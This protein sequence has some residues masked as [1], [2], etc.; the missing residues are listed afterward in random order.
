MNA[1]GIYVIWAV[2]V[3]LFT[4]SWW[5]GRIRAKEIHSLARSCGFQHLGEALP[6]SLLLTN[7]PFTSITSVWNVI[8][9]EPRGKRIIAFDCRFGN[10]KA[11]WRRTVIA[12]KTEI[13]NITASAFDPYLRIE[14]M[15]DWVLIYRPKEFALISRGMIPIPE[16]RAYLDTI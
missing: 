2:M 16:L 1:A 3:V 15:N 4:L 10:G 12:I 5:R 11:S 7:A 8:D 6:R 13:S 9:G 14:Q